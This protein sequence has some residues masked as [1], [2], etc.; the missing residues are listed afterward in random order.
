LACDKNLLLQVDFH[1]RYDPY[2]IE[3]NQ[4]VDAEKIGKLLY[5]YCHMEDKITVPAE[6]F[7]HWANKSSPAWFLGS[8]FIDLIGWLMK[9]PAKTIFATGQKAKLVSMGIDTYDSIQATVHYANDAVITYHQAWILPEQ[10]PAIVNQGFRLVGTEGIVEVDT[11]QRGTNSCITSEPHMKTHNSGFIYTTK[12]PDGSTIYKG[13]G[14]ESIQHFVHNIEFLKKGG[15]I[16]DLRG[17][18]P[19]GDDGYE[20]TRIIEAMHESIETAKVIHI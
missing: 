3:I 10:F 6:W 17:S 8:N 16:E 15:T 19:S 7:P 9:S 2:H 13:Y 18:Y 20:V 14:I 11:Q 5:G 1:K 4:L 12:R